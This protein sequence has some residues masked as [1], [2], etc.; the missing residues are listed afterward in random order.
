VKLITDHLGGGQECVEIFLHSTTVFTPRCLFCYK[1]SDTPLWY[2]ARLVCLLRFVREPLKGFSR[3]LGVE[4]FIKLG[5]HMPVLANVGLQWWVL[6]E[7]LNVSDITCRE[8]WNMFFWPILVWYECI[9][10]CLTCLN[11]TDYMLCDLRTRQSYG[12]FFLSN[13][14]VEVYANLPHL[15][16]LLTKVRPDC[17]C[18]WYSQSCWQCTVFKYLQC[19]VSRRSC[20]VPPLC[21]ATVA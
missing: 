2:S 13:L 6:C 4:S 12:T 10:S 21:W 5:R 9:S 19:D 20:A 15:N 7:D 14:V 3:N 17:S 1:V 16:T 18:L 8:K 11:M